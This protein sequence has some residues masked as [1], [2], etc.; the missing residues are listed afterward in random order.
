MTIK[1]VEK[2]DIN[3]V[4]EIFLLSI[5]E[6]ERAKTIQ[7]VPLHTN[8]WWLRSPGFNSNL[9]V[10]VSIRGSINGIGDFVDGINSAIRPAFKVKNIESNIGNKVFVKNTVCT[11]I[12]KDI[13]LSDTAICFHR[14]D[15]KYSD[16][17]KSEIKEFL[18]S[19]E[20]KDML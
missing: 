15:E 13:V 5:D 4:E 16:Y 14:F 7:T 10:Y 6:W 3:E 11:V 2:F 19:D 9:A 8:W 20:F 1:S 18:H 12:D 17:E